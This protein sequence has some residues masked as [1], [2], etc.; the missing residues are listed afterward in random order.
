MVKY[1]RE[2]DNPTKSCKA[3]GSDLRVHFKVRRFSCYCYF[4]SFFRK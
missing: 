3:R 1:S 2:P 4:F